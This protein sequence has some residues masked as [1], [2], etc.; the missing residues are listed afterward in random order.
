MDNQERILALFQNANQPLSAK[1]IAEQTGVDKKEVDK[2]IKK[3][4][5]EEKIDSPKRCYY[6][7]KP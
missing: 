1:E 2:I 3:L 7:L 6:Q 4:K 5:K